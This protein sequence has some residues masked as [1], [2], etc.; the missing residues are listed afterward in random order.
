M[1]LAGVIRP[2][3]PVP[4]GTFLACKYTVA[5]KTSQQATQKSKGKGWNTESILKCM[6]LNF[7][8]KLRKGIILL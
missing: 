5:L 7:Q 1:I 4:H 6:Q 2:L 8:I 3:T